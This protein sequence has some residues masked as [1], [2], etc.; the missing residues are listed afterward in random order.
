[1]KGVCLHVCGGILK[2]K[3]RSGFIFLLLLWTVLYVRDVEVQP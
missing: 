3:P 2:E 1:M